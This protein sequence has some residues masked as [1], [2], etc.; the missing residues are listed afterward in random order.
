[1][2]IAYVTTYNAGERYY[3]SGSGQAIMECLRK[4]SIEV[5]PFGP[6]RTHHRWL[7]RIKGV[8][9]SRLFHRSY[10]FEREALPAY[11]Y[12]SQVERKLKASRYDVVFSPGTIPI[13]RLNCRQPIVVWADATFASYISHY[14]LDKTLCR[15]TIR[16]GHRSECA[17]YGRCAL[18]IFTS[19]WAAKSALSDYGLRPEKVK[20]V[21]FGPNFLE[22]P[23]DRKALESIDSRPT[24][25]CRL[26]TIGVDWFRKGVPK[27]I[28]LAAILNS[29]GIRTT[30]DVVGCRA[31]ASLLVPPFVNVVGYI[32]KRTSDGERKLTNLL[33]KS[34]FHVLFST[35]EAFGVVFAEANAHAVP[36][37][38]NDVGGV[39][40]AVLNDRGGRCFDPMTPVA[41]V[42]EYIESHIREHNSYSILARKARKEYEHRLNWNVSGALVRRHLENVISAPPNV[43]ADAEILSTPVLQRPEGLR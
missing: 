34:H 8:F 16:A 2:K 5:V 18:L 27:A 22:L 6:L 11:G 17:A 10:D 41:S 7:G 25:C 3:W 36:N 31:P 35:A 4:Q 28:E 15:E 14:G 43:A 12:A 1:M 39:S 33:L 24:D 26:I 20:V 38:A 42:A 21:P 9:Y 13:S 29:R 23:T 30:L 40:T 19:E 32:D 37:I